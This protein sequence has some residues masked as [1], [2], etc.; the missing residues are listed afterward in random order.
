MRVILAAFIVPIDSSC[1][2]VNKNFFESVGESFVII[3]MY[4]GVKHFSYKL[5]DVTIL[6]KCADTFFRFVIGRP[7]TRPF[8]DEAFL[9]ERRVSPVV[10][11]IAMAGDEGN[12]R[13][14]RSAVGP[15]SR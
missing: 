12:E 6:S 15:Y 11:V 9:N 13:A 10:A 2:R 3:V 5:T 1:L 4:I 7:V 14:G 8:T